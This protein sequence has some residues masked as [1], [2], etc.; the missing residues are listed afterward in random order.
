QKAQRI[1]EISRIILEKHG[2]KVPADRNLLME[3]PGVGPKT[4]DVTLC[5]GFGEPTIP[6]DTHVNR[7]SRRLGLVQE[8]AKIED[9]GPTLEKIFPRKD[10]RLVNRGLVLFGREICLPRYPRCHLCELRRVCKTGRK[11]TS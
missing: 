6:V 8:K 7:I 5:Y 1:K 11:L 9:V 4:A 10:W 2:G 3:L